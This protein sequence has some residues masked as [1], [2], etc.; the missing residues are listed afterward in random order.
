MPRI[1][2]SANDPLDFCVRCYPTEG[3]AAT[4]YGNVALTGEGP[5]GRGNCFGYDAE[6]PDYEYEDYKCTSCHR[7][8]KGKDN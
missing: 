8:L 5:D 1:Y 7:R 2:D 4:K 3:M 6:H